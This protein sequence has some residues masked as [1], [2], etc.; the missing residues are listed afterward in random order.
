M[1][2]HN[3][4]TT[5]QLNALQ[6]KNKPYFMY[7]AYQGNGKLAVRVSAK[8]DGNT[9][10]TFYFFYKY[11]GKQDGYSLGK[12]G[13]KSGYMTLKQAR[14]RATV[15]R[16]LLQQHINP[17]THGKRYNDKTAK[18]DG[19]LQDMMRV[20]TNVFNNTKVI[21]ENVRYGTIPQAQQLLEQ[22]VYPHIARDTQANKIEVDDVKY[23]LSLAYKWGNEEQEHTERANR[24]NRVRQVLA[25]LWRDAILH[26]NDPDVSPMAKKFNL[27]SN[28]FK[29]VIIKMR[30]KNAVVDNRIYNV[31]QLMYMMANIPDHN[32]YLLALK[33]VVLMGGVRLTNIVNAKWD[34]VD[35]DARVFTSSIEL[36]KARNN[37][38]A[39]SRPHLIPLT[40]AALAVLHNIHLHTGRNEY[41]FSSEILSNA[42]S[43]YPCIDHKAVNHQFVKWKSA[44]PVEYQGIVPRNLRGSV[45]TIFSKNR[46]PKDVRNRI[47]DHGNT[48]DIGDAHYNENDYLPEMREAL[49]L[50]ESLVT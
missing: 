36:R 28:M 32:V 34:C 18:T 5:A 44:H 47:Q 7:E 49:E 27:K 46:I 48:T 31:D 12:Y 10:V 25:N 37:A 30:A 19:T 38:A 3:T 39:I 26:D 1:A 43:R 21:N 14:E 15:C 45:N 6:A 17:K 22:H 8:R 4:F 13:N 33:L 50:I 42:A 9:S 41:I 40:N 29:E 16:Q 24:V 35:F 11:L 2:T 20:Y 23:I